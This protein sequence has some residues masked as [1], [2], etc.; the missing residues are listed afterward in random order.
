[1]SR[2][3]RLEHRLKGLGEIREIL[4][5]MKSLA[6][7]E[8]RK[9]APLLKNQRAVVANIV[10]AAADF[11]A[12][13]PAVA[14]SAEPAARV[15]VLIGSERGFCGDFNQ[16]LRRDAGEVAAPAVAKR[17]LVGRKLHDL[18]PTDERVALLEG[19]GVAG[20]VGGVLDRIVAELLAL[21]AERGMLGL[22]ARYHDATGR[23]VTREVLPPFRGLPPPGK[24]YRHPPVLNLPPAALLIELTD[25][26]VLAAL[27]EL[28]YLSLM[29]ENQRRVTHLTDA[30]RHLDDKT[31]AMTRRANALRQEEIVE[32]IE[33]ILLSVTSLA[34]ERG[35]ARPRR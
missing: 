2:R 26:Y 33:V 10:E 20:E 3:R 5:A 21:Q 6:Y 22:R 13:E 28:L 7:M 24:R 29:N 9:L 35:R 27:H 23:I 12:F 11:L 25:H 1:M 14:I 8:T 16:A 15:E 32:E 4:N 30:V 31:A 34:E 19:A 18:V 17:L